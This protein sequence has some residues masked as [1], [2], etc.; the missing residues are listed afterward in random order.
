MITLLRDLQDKY[1]LS[2]VFISHDLSVV[3]ALS[4]K[5]LVLKNGRAVEYGEAS[6]I[7]SAPQHEYTRELLGAALFYTR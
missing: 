5:L 4:H 1:G 3:R 7:F 2:Y 6:G